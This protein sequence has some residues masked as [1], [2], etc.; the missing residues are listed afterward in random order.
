MDEYMDIP[1]PDDFHVHLR[2]GGAMRLYAARHAASFGRALVM[3]NT[4]PP[5]SDA[6]SMLRYKADIEACLSSRAG[7]KFTAEK[8]VQ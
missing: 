5:V 6:P 8:F 4:N 3:P 7:G 1:K 2:Q